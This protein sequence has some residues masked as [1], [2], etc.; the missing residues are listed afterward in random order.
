MHSR[1]RLR[2]INTYQSRRDAG[3]NNA[4][5]QSLENVAAAK[6]FMPCTRTPNAIFHEFGAHGMSARVAA[7][8]SHCILPGDWRP[9]EFANGAL[10]AY[11]LSSAQT[12]KPDKVPGP[13]VWVSGTSAASRPRAMRTRPIRG[14]LLR[15]SNVCQRPPR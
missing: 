11:G 1:A 8:N 7:S 15:G 3:L 14:V 9:R 2:A 13:K 5:K 6:P 10:G 12:R 4:F